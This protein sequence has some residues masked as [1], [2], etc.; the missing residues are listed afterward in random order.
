MLQG[1]GY[2][3]IELATERVHMLGRNRLGPT[4]SLFI[5]NIKTA[6][7]VLG[8]TSSLRLN[9]CPESS[10]SANYYLCMQ[11]IVTYNAFCSRFTL[12]IELI[13]FK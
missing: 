7:S 8:C 1:L 6:S 10:Q 2:F 3:L 13:I 9:A 11:L 5:G 4:L 12:G